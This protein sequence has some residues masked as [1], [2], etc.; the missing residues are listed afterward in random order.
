MIGR[1]SPTSAKVLLR[2]NARIR[3]KGET[4]GLS[5]HGLV[6]GVQS[7]WYPDHRV[8]RFLSTSGSRGAEPIKIATRF[9]CILITEVDVCVPGLEQVFIFLDGHVG[10]GG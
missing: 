4:L 5:R 1:R 7:D 9:R 3:E 6:R 2:R 10:A 8:I